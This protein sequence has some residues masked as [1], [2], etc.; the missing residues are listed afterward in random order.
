MSI[1]PELLLL[2]RAVDRHLVHDDQLLE[3]LRELSRDEEASVVDLL[4]SHGLSADQLDSLM[5]YGSEYDTLDA[6]ELKLAQMA[7]P[8]AIEQ[9]LARS[10]TVKGD[11]TAE[12]R[13]FTPPGPDDAGG[14]A[15]WKSVTSADGGPGPI[16][17]RVESQQEFVLMSEL[18]RGGLGRV[19]L[20]FDRRLGRQVAVKELLPQSLRSREKI[21]RFLKEARVTGQLE[22]PGV[23]PVY[24]AGEGEDGQPFY[25]MKRIGGRTFSQAIRAYHALPADDPLRPQRFSELLTVFVSICQTMAFAH[26]RGVLHRDLKPQNVIVG[27]FGEAIVVDWG[28]AKT[29]APPAPRGPNESTIAAEE[30]AQPAAPEPIELDDDAAAATRD[31]AVL[32]TLAYMSPEQAL[33]MAV[34]ARSDI[35]ALGAMLFELLAN[36]PPFRGKTQEVLQ[37]VQLGKL[38][39]LRELAPHAPRALEAVCMRALARLPEARYATAKEL[40]DEVVRWQAGEP[41]LAYAEPWLERGLRWTRRHRTLCATALA[42]LAVLATVAGSWWWQ[43]S[44]RV[45][46]VADRA[47]RHMQTADQLLLAEQL[48]AALAEVDQ[49]RAL[50]GAE[51]RLASI[52][53]AAAELRA[54]IDERLSVDANRQRLTRQLADFERHYHEALFRSLLAARPDATADRAAALRSLR[55]ARDLLPP[56]QVASLGAI[57]L[58]AADR[59]EVD[60][61]QQELSIVEAELMA[62]PAEDRDDAARA[63]A[64]LAA[65]ACVP[66]DAPL[67]A[68]A[69]RRARYLRLAGRDDE[70][71]RE[72]Q[73]AGQIEPQHSLDLFLLGDQRL[74]AEDLPAAKRYFQQALAAQP[75][76]FWAQWYLAV[77]Q[78]QSGEPR[79]A[80]ASLSACASRRPEFGFTYLLRG[81]AHGELG[82]LEL[83]EDDFRR[84]A[85]LIPANETRDHYA[86][87]LNRGLVRVEHGRLPDAL[88]D[89]A[90]AEKL[91]PTR[92]EAHVNRADALRRRDE[93]SAALAS[94]GL[95]LAG[96]PLTPVATHH[97]ALAQLERAIEFAPNEP[98]AYLNRGAIWRGLGQSNQALADFRQALSVSRPA[99]PARAQALCEY[100]RLAHAGGDPQEALRRYNAAI[101]DCP[102]YADALYLRGLAQMDLGSDQEAIESFDA[103]LA[104]SQLAARVFGQVGSLARPV[105]R[106]ASATNEATQLD[107][108]SEPRQRL[109]AIYRERALAR[110]KLRDTLGAFSDSILA[111]D[112]AGPAAE[113][114]AQGDRTRFANLHARRGWALLLHGAEMARA[115]FD[116]A[117]QLGGASGDPYT[118]R[119][120]A[121]VLLG[122]CDEAVADAMAALRV[123]PITPGLLYNA[124]SIHAAAAGRVLSGGNTADER[125]AGWMNEALALLER[126]FSTMSPRERAAYRQELAKDASFDSIRQRPEF[127]R[128]LTDNDSA[129]TP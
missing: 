114:L 47:Q 103:F 60:L 20:A 112:L 22:H 55:A 24:A 102:A 35:Y 117:I 7:G 67:R 93:A 11:E 8:T 122:R 26:Q 6:E 63:H 89:F 32:G 12:T 43:E 120:S 52:A 65:L 121:L 75:D 123:G 108:G 50:A 91:D 83:A 99:T 53:G 17:S 27:D 94:L 25:A 33:G 85:R 104:Q 34:D 105:G 56:A 74:A 45:Q 128:L 5:R 77:A 101:D 23:V 109:A 79:E 97:A 51:P 125:P 84:A 115:S 14:R 124:A 42:S 3:L 66:V 19:R 70:A 16:G 58:D 86:L 80:L 59:A 15:V 69:D 110:L 73:R 49:A 113:S 10:S 39:R 118:G 106:T 92:W 41:P 38:P 82:E 28:L 98:R 107:E 18:G 68:V 119:G 44:R 64:A 126:G 4:R 37:Q 111:L 61:K 72:S 62:L 71:Q 40:A 88:A 48:P 96:L 31:G 78:L 100:G 81:L 76:R 129:A 46:Q 127:A 116:E 29:L 95:R 36:R 90:A 2:A 13:E 1:H 30:L 87:H 54:Q 57:G 9:R 21:R